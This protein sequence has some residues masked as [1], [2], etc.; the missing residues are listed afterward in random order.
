MIKKLFEGDILA[1]PVIGLLLFVAIFFTAL[2]WVLRRGRADHYDH[3]SS[4]PLG[5]DV[6]SA[7]HNS[8]APEVSR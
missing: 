2:I 5:S 8:S 1:L 3:M 4:L 6:A 7:D